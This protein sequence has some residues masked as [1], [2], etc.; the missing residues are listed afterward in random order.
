MKVR[1][2]T[3]YMLRRY[4]GNDLWEYMFES[5]ELYKIKSDNGEE[6]CNSYQVIDDILDDGERYVEL[7][8]VGVGWFFTNK[9]RLLKPHHWYWAHPTYWTR[10]TIGKVPH[11]YPALS[12]NNLGIR[13]HLQKHFGIEDKNE[14]LKIRMGL[15][16][17]MER[18]KEYDII[19]KTN[20]YT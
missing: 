16:D 11:A 5:Q 10:T 2:I 1:E 20:P 8:D 14:A 3:N 9:G 19:R 7:T 4:S 13:L 17:M 18:K 15:M 6:E 12:N